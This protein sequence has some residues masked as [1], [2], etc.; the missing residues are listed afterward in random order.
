MT[1]SLEDRIR[2]KLSV[3][4]LIEWYKREILNDEYVPADK[5]VLFYQLGKLEEIF[6][7]DQAE[8]TRYY[9]LAYKQDSS[10][11]LPIVSAGS[12]LFSTK[13]FERLLRLYE[14]AID[15]I[16]D[17]ALKSAIIMFLVDALVGQG[18]IEGMQDYLLHLESIGRYPIHA[19]IFKEWF[20]L[21]SRGDEEV[22]GTLEKWKVATEHPLVRAHLCLELARDSENRGNTDLALEILREA[23]HNGRDFFPTIPELMRMGV[24][25]GNTAWLEEVI[26]DDISSVSQGGDPAS[27]F[28]LAEPA[29]GEEAAVMLANFLSTFANLKQ[30]PLTDAAKETLFDVVHSAVKDGKFPEC[31]SLLMDFAQGSK[32]VDTLSEAIEYYIRQPLEPLDKVWLYWNL[33]KVNLQG[34]K[35]QEAIEIIKEIKKL[36]YTSRILDSLISLF[37]LNMG[38]QNE[39]ITY[40]ESLSGEESRDVVADAILAD[41]QWS[42]KNNLGGVVETLRGYESFSY[43][44]EDLA[45]IAAVLTDNNSLKEKALEEKVSG[46]ES[47]HLLSCT[48][49]VRF[50]A[51]ERPNLEKF[52]TV[53]EKFAPS[54]RAFAVWASLLGFLKSFEGRNDEKRALFLKNIAVNVSSNA[55]FPYMFRQWA[56]KLLGIEILEEEKGEIP[57]N[58]V[59]RAP[60]GY[61]TLLTNAATPEDAPAIGRWVVD[62]LS[63]ESEGSFSATFL[64]HA[65]REVEKVCNDPALCSELNEALISSPVIAE[66]FPDLAMYLV[67][68]EKNLERVLGTLNEANLL[69]DIK[70]YDKDHQ[71]P[72]N[73]ISAFHAMF[74]E[75]DFAKA[76][77]SL[78]K[79]RFNGKIDNESMFLLMFNLPLC[80]RWKEWIDLWANRQPNRSDEIEGKYEIDVGRAAMVARL[81]LSG[82]LKGAVESADEI[83]G[84]RKGDPVSLIVKLFEA[85]KGKA[86]KEFV[87]T[88]RHI[89]IWISDPSLR[90]KISFHVNNLDAME[91]GHAGG[92]D[93]TLVV[94]DIVNM[95]C[96]IAAV[97]EG[98][99]IN[100]TDE[101]VKSSLAGFRKLSDNTFKIAG[102]IELGEF[103]ATA[104]RP[105]EALEA[106]QEALK[107]NPNEIGAIL[108]IMRNARPLEE[109]AMLGWAI[110]RYAEMT[111]DTKRS[112]AR[113]VEAAEEYKNAERKE[114][115]VI[116]CYN[117]AFELDP[118][119]DKSFHGLLAAIE[120]KGDVKTLVTLI[121]RRVGT[122]SEYNELQILLLKLAD[123][124]RKVKDMDGALVAVEDLLLITPEDASEKVVA[125]R[126]KMD[127][128]IQMGRSENAFD[129]GSQIASSA[130]DKKVRKGIIQKCINLAFQKLNMPEKGLGFCIR[131]IEEGEADQEFINKTLRIALKLEKWDEA[132]A[133]QD[134]LAASAGTEKER[135]N[136]LLKK[137]EIY[138]RYAKDLPRA[139][140]EYKKIL[141]EDTGRWEALTRWQ[142]ARGGRYLT[143]EELSEFIDRA[144]DALDENPLHTGVINVLIRAN[145][146]LMNTRTARYYEGIYNVLSVSGAKKIPSPPGIR[147]SIPLV[148]RTPSGF[149]DP[150]DLEGLFRP[151][152][153]VKILNDVLRALGRKEIIGVLK[154]EGII[155]KAPDV[156]LEN[157]ESPVVKYIQSWA[158]VFGID[159]LQVFRGTAEDDSLL[160]H[161]DI[162]MGIVVGSQLIV[163]LVP[164]ALFRLGFHLFNVSQGL[165][166]MNIIEEKKMLGLVAAAVKLCSD[167]DMDMEREEIFTDIL[168]VGID[169][170]VKG[171]VIS[172]LEKSPSLTRDDVIGW[173]TAMY[174]G[175]LKAGHTVSGKIESLIAFSCSG[176]KSLEDMS[177]EDIEE[178][179][180][181]DA[182]IKEALRFAL[183]RR[184]EVLRQGVGL[185]L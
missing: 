43:G 1:N 57:G 118:S 69:F 59:L 110:E 64:A 129:V 100:L 113:Y 163:P 88:L 133:I 140:E 61:Y 108:G 116:R 90:G 175:A 150:D 46:G 17:T 44:M 147:T 121:E 176:T 33:V 168:F 58:N 85:Q 9:L 81:A 179:F 49:Q 181:S 45:Y 145:R 42:Y 70:E 30:A 62:N 128:L 138:L 94:P 20:Q 5:A 177:R 24:R 135:A 132:A 80:M 106:Y 21:Q 151:D 13:S 125:L 183:S 103:L 143:Q 55:F 66:N 6:N 54:S 25:T 86:R 156:E 83:L 52:F 167:F 178:L 152:D 127:I 155:G 97:V 39:M 75:K 162:P 184:Y 50:Y 72:L 11:V 28:L 134:R 144:Y 84:V 91:G 78:Q 154:H 27:R 14:V 79:N 136:C 73:I 18:K 2:E 7:K 153:K 60:I 34:G 159:Q 112:A 93:E 98:G 148:G 109:Y 142:A 174:G 119:N 8:A 35:T 15:T 131:L 68:K 96:D 4:T 105:R 104:A 71:I 12:I 170:G 92:E 122:I 123:L 102:L 165:R 111:P 137:A 107:S 76:V 22:I 180:K 38:R 37:Q 74:F 171:S 48:E 115:N 41:L 120:H 77:D 95:D 146:I 23:A 36:G 124:K 19:L 26:I 157:P 160:A 31:L 63:R 161:P 126:L 40:M 82:D 99:L 101:V 47:K 89:G 87:R 16:T 141:R 56:G 182:R 149:F 117:V 3:D 166:L 65:A 29:S 169:K 164:D 114:E 32:H 172:V 67:L 185:E 130:K 53:A 51:F 10:F 173:F 139:E 158:G